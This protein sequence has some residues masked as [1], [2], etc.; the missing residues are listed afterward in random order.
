[1]ESV[2]KLSTEVATLGRA[3]AD[4]GGL[5][6]QGTIFGGHATAAA[7]ELAQFIPRSPTMAAPGR[8]TRRSRRSRPCSRPARSGDLVVLP[9]SPD[10]RDVAGAL[11]ALTGMGVLVN[12]TAVRWSDDGPV[13][14][15]SAF[16]GRLITECAFSDIAAGGIITVRPNSVTAEPLAAAGSV[17]AATAES[18]PD[19]GPAGPAS[20]GSRRRSRRERPDRGCPDHRLGRPR[21][22]WRRRLQAR[23]ITRRRARWCRRSQ[24]RGC[25]LGLD[26]VRPAD[27]PDRQDREAA[28][29]PGARHQRGHPAQGRDADGR[30]R[31]WRSTAIRTRRSP[32]SRT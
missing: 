29:V 15:Q 25:R 5:E 4:A 32:I 24:P 10:G 30:D 28:A 12:A 14:E 11:S 18:G 23:A 17:T 3:L 26:P 7:S 9:A 19:R 20:S 22:R 8:P 2:T 16:G 6:L 13:V 21:G 1:M 27:R 31:S